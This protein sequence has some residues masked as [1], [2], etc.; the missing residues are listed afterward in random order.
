MESIDHSP[1]SGPFYFVNQELHSHTTHFLDQGIMPP[2]KER[3]HLSGTHLLQCPF[4]EI[5]L[6]QLDNFFIESSYIS[7]IKPLNYEI[8]Y[9][10]THCYSVFFDFFW[11]YPGAA[12]HVE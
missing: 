4:Q 2:P 5:N 10:H 9:R 7:N 6:F 3:E 1:A 8:T 11:N 12:L